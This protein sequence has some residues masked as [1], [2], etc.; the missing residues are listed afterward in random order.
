MSALTFDPWAALKRRSEDAPPPKAPKVAKVG[1]QEGG[2]V[3]RSEDGSPPKAPKVA[4]V[5]GREGGALG[6]LV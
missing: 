2:A 5:G 6:G 4:K 3:L 1:G